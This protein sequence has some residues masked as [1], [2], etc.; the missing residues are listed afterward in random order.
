MSSW[1]WAGRTQ[2]VIGGPKGSTRCGES[3]IRTSSVKSGAYRLSSA[4]ARDRAHMVGR[5]VGSFVGGHLGPRTAWAGL[6]AIAVSRTAVS[7]TARKT[8]YAVRIENSASP[9]FTQQGVGSIPWSPLAWEPA[10]VVQPMP[11]GDPGP[12]PA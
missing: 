4:V 12:G 2:I 6:C 1:L 11:D 10:E 9:L 3:T 5:H 8:V 7:S